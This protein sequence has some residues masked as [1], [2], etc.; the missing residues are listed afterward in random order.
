MLASRLFS[1]LEI[2]HAGSLTVVCQETQFSIIRD[3]LFSVEAAFFEVFFVCFFALFVTH[4]FSSVWASIQHFITR[5]LQALY[6]HTGRLCKS[7]A[8]INLAI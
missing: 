4:V 2:I 3:L 8:V 5:S 1:S 7:S 6:L